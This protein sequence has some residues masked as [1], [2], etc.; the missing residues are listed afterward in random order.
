[1]ERGCCGKTDAPENVLAGVKGVGD[2]PEVE[3]MEDKGGDV[4]S[5]SLKEHAGTVSVEQK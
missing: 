3:W 2:G 1:M 5:V 4:C